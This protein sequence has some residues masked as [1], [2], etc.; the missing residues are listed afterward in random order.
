MHH[1]RFHMAEIHGGAFTIM[2][3]GMKALVVWSARC[4]LNTRLGVRPLSSQ[5][6]SLRVFSKFSRILAGFRAWGRHSMTSS[7]GLAEASGFDPAT[8]NCALDMA[9]TTRRRQADNVS[10]P[11]EAE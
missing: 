9:G 11:L 10:E 4:R 2:L 3:K 1:Q 5:E 8:R 6:I 7:F